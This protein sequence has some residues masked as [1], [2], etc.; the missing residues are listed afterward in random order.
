MKILYGVHIADGKEVYR[1]GYSDIFK[2]V[3][4]AEGIVKAYTYITKIK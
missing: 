2:K 3:I 4:N 1:Y